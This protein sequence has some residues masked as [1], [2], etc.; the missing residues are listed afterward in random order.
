VA[1]KYILHEDKKE[2]KIKQSGAQYLLVYR[3]RNLKFGKNFA[4]DRKISASVG[5]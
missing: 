5:N 1:T 4:E 3:M 2:E